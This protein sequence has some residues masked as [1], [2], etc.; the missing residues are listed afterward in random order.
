MNVVKYFFKSYNQGFLFNIIIILELVICL[1]MGTFLYNAINEFSEEFTDYSEYENYWSGA[2]D[3]EQFDLCIQTGIV[4]NMAINTRDMWRNT[5]NIPA[6]GR[7]DWNIFN[8]NAID[9]MN[10][11]M[12]QGEWFDT[13]SSEH[14]PVVLG[15]LYIEGNEFHH[16]VSLGQ[17]FEIHMPNKIDKWATLKCQ[18]IG[19]C[20]ESLNGINIYGE[21]GAAAAQDNDSQISDSCVMVMSN[22]QLYEFLYESE[23]EGQSY[24]EKVSVF[25]NSLTAKDRTILFEKGVV[26]A[27]TAETL[28]DWHSGD[29]EAAKYSIIIFVGVALLMI[30]TILMAT[31]ISL[32]N[33]IREN[34]LTFM[35]GMTPTQKVVVE[36]CK[37]LFT[38]VVPFLL[39]WII[40]SIMAPTGI[41]ISTKMTGF[42]LASA[43]LFLVYLLSNLVSTIILLKT[44]PLE[45]LKEE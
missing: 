20:K 11:T 25:S 12:V 39:C 33:K 8:Q 26:L 27:N 3:K 1:I 14:I 44:K 4:D 17:V 28:R 35:F 36:I 13:A 2:L 23:I 32:K 22:E 16:K 5:I 29:I 6:L 30:S 18:V 19:F 34:S 7:F 10:P 24:D 45:G 37:T 40:M 31:M 38:F 41:L 42:Y 43:I 9:L 21:V 15:N